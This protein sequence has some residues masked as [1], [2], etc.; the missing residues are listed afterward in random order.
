MR[1]HMTW[2]EEIANRFIITGYIYE[3]IQLIYNFMKKRKRYI[4]EFKLN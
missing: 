4:Q 3:L 1:Q 2:N